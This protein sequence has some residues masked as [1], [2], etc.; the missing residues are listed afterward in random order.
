MKSFVLLNPC[1]DKEL[2]RSGKP[3]RYTVLWAGME[4][5]FTAIDVSL[6]CATRAGKNLVAERK[7]GFESRPLPD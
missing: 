1:G 5:I 4:W 6:G 7:G 2:Q 3:L